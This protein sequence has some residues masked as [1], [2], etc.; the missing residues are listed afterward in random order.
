MMMR[1][2]RLAMAMMMTKSLMSDEM[3]LVSRVCRRE[4]VGDMDE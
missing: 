2:M 4:P 3:S 1:R